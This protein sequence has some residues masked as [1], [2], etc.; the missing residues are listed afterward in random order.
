LEVVFLE[1]IKLKVGN[2]AGM[3]GATVLGGVLGSFDSTRTRRNFRKWWY[4]C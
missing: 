2:N 3:I 4:K 1:I